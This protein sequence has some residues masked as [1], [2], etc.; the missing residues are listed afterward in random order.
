MYA[1]TGD[2]EILKSY[3]YIYIY[4]IYKL[5]GYLHDHGMEIKKDN[6]ICFVLRKNT[7][8]SVQFMSIIY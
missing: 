8:N 4:S 6:S 7:L 2:F 5:L 1:L 3:I